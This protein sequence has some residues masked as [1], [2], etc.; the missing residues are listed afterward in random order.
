MLCDH[1]ADQVH[2]KVSVQPVLLSKMFIR[3]DLAGA[4]QAVPAL[5]DAVDE[6]PEVEIVMR[7]SFGEDEVVPSSNLRLPTSTNGSSR[8]RWVDGCRMYDGRVSSRGGS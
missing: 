8:S 6:Q 5:A 2:A 1:P 3:H 4:V 7:Y